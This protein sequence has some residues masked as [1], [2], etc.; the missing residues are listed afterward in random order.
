MNVEKHNRSVKLLC[1]RCKGSGFSHSD[2]ASSA[3][4]TVT[5]SACNHQLTRDALIEANRAA[6]NAEADI[7][8]GAIVKDL[9][10]EIKK[11]LGGN[12]TIK[13]KL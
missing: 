10:N 13:I 12:K 7:M 9:R 2:E 1:P 5:C 8:K 3:A 4:P 11:A 6:I